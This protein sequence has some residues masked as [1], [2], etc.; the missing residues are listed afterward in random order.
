M[1]TDRAAATLWLYTGSQRFCSRSRGPLER[2]GRA[3]HQC[4]EQHAEDTGGAGSGRMEGPP[5][6]GTLEE[7][8]GCLTKQPKL[9]VPLLVAGEVSPLPTSFLGFSSFVV[10][11]IIL[12]CPSRE[13]DYVVY[14]PHSRRFF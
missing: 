12:H 6:W 11:G 1:G 3:P 13:R 8:P 10:F 5:V 4:S 2:K 9:R 14:I 7:V